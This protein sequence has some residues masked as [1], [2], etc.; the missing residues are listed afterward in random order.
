MLEIKLLENKYALHQTRIDR[1][2]EGIQKMHVNYQYLFRHLQQ[3]C[4]DSNKECMKAHLPFAK[5]IKD[6]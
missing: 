6:R 2:K 1:L 3:H 4:N 5:K